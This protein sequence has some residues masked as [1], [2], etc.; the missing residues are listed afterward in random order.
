[1]GLSNYPPFKLGH[2]PLALYLGQHHVVNSASLDR[3]RIA[4]EARLDPSLGQ[5]KGAVAVALGLGCGD[6]VRAP[7][8]ASIDGDRLF[9]E[10]VL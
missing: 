4:R 10:P 9:A 6:P 8:P 2:H 5:A 3:R 7:S 1:M